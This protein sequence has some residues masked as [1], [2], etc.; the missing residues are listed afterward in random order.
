M[1][2]LEITEAIFGSL[3]P[4]IMDDNVTDIKWNGKNVWIDDLKK[5][6]YIAKNDRGGDLKLSNDWIEFFAK[7]LSNTMNVNFNASSPSLQAETDELRIHIVHKFVS[8]EEGYSFTIRKTPSISRL[9]KI[10]LVGTGYFD[11]MMEMIL[12]AIIR[13]RMAGCVIG[14]VGAGKTELEKYLCQFIPDTDG[15]ITVEDT[16]E[17]KLPKLYPKKDIISLKV[18][19]SY[20]AVDAIRDALRLMTKWLILSEAR[21][22]EIVQVMEAASTGCVAMTSIH[23]ENAWDIPDRMLNMAG[24]ESREGFENDIYTFFNYAVKVKKEV[25]N[26]NGGGITRKVDQLVFFSRE[27]GENKLTIFYKNG[28]LTG[29]Q[30]PASILEKMRNETE[31]LKFYCETFGLEYVDQSD[32]K[33]TKEKPIDVEPKA[34]ADNLSAVEN[35]DIPETETTES[36]ADDFNNELDNKENPEKELSEE[37]PVDEKIEESSLLKELKDLE[38]KDSDSTGILESEEVKVNTEAANEIPDD[39]EDLE[40]IVE[41]TDDS[42]KD[43]MEDTIAIKEMNELEDLPDLENDSSLEETKEYKPVLENKITEENDLVIKDEVS[44]SST[45]DIT[46]SLVGA[47]RGLDDKTL[48]ELRDR[49][50]ISKYIDNPT[51]DEKPVQNEEIKDMEEIEDLPD[52]DE[53]PFDEISADETSEVKSEDSPKDDFIP[54]MPELEDIVDE[55][56]DEN[57]EPETKTPEPISET[58]ELEDISEIE[59]TE[60]NLESEEDLTIAKNETVEEDLL[61]KDAENLEVSPK[62]DEVIEEPIKSSEEKLDELMSDIGKPITIDPKIYKEVLEPKNELNDNIENTINNAEDNLFILDD[63]G[64][65]SEP[66]LDGVDDKNDFEPF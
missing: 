35:S 24:D 42:T 65:P 51:I 66:E 45:P 15:I 26:D 40:D 53:N 11:K 13:S 47:V 58:S 22:R 2:R 64:L 60:D 10:D 3:Y 27:N 1:Q 44:D 25:D 63:E 28:K 59:P 20:S 52:M 4:F 56:I 36:V 29:E 32:H 49:Y 14:D 9:A 39:L 55:P 31:F 30:I 17:M 12:P 21:G 43:E 7:K 19:D 37:V 8:G 34:I 33:Q 62:T 54:E 38:D 61:L 57:P 5:G 50:S 18:S 23:A 41:K 48:E 46:D 6:R 16:L